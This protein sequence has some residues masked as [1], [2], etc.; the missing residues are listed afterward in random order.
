MENMNDIVKLAVDYHHGCVEKYSKSQAEEVLRQ[1][2]IEANGGKDYLDIHDLQSGKASEVFRL[3]EEIL[4][5]TVPEGLTG[6]E[7]YN[8]FVEYRNVAE[9]DKPVFRVKN[10]DVFVVDEIADGTQA[11]RRQRIGGETEFTVKTK[12]YGIR[13]YEE[14]NRILSK[15]ADINELISKVTEAV[16]KHQQDMIFAAW[17]ALS[18]TEMGGTTYFPAAGSYDEDTLLDL[19][20]HVEAVADGKPAVIIGTKKAL[21]KLKVDTDLIGNKI[22]D[23]FYNYGYM[24]KFNGT[25]V[26]AIPNRHK[27]GSTEF[28]MPDDELTIV[29]GE[30]RMIKVVTEGNPLIIYKQ[31]IDNMDLTQEYLYI[32][33]FG[34]A[35]VTAGKNAGIGRYKITG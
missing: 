15:R 27:V 22:R 19:I 18:A 13:I 23:D 16:I 24:G 30:D 2:L 8:R 29:A 11:L 7:F 5:V 17:S 32:E 26:V 3:I 33:K 12:T 10:N 34:I 4:A 1:A 31:A 21:R 9:G 20:A 35:V 6:T 25:D 28:I 14:L